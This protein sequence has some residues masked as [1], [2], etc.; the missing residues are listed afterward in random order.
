MKNYLKSIQKK[1]FPFYK[2]ELEK[3]DNIESKIEKIENSLRHL[4]EKQLDPLIIHNIYY[5]LLDI[6]LK[7]ERPLIGSAEWFEITEYKYG[8]TIKN[9]PRKKVSNKDSRTK[10]QLLTGG[11]TGGDRMS[12]IEHNYAPV[13]SKFLAPFIKNK[14]QKIILLEIGILKGT[15]LAIWSELFPNG[16]IIGLDIDLSHIHENMENI[17]SLGAFQNNNIELYE[18]DQ[19][20]DN[21]EKLTNILNGDKIDIIIDDGLHWNETIINTINSVKPFLADIFIYFIEDNL[22][23]HEILIN[24]FPEYIINCYGQITVMTNKTSYQKIK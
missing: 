18:F 11:M 23:I 9:V 16:R 22:K 5:S 2:I 13:Y 17:K 19:F 1:I 10:N 15:G 14:N 20:N 6:K 24:M 21:R 3:I 7:Y 4:S 8:G 12:K